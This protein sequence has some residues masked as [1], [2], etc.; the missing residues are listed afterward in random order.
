[1][2]D[3][4]EPRPATPHTQ[5][6]L[7][8]LE[9]PAPSRPSDSNRRASMT[10]GVILLVAG[11][12]WIVA[13]TGWFDIGWRSM[14]AG[15]L[16]V[17]GVAIA[18]IGLSDH[19]P[20]PLVGLGVVLTILLAVTLTV[21]PGVVAGGI[22]DRVEAPTGVS[23]LQDAYRLGIGTLTV[24]LTELSLPA[25]TTE[26]TASVGLGELVVIVPDDVG[27]RVTAD[28]QAGDI[29]VFGD[30]RSGLGPQMELTAE[31]DG[32]DTADGAGVLDLDLAAVFGSIEVRHP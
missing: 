10:V 5:I 14:T 20:G 7:T 6:D 2:S 15:A 16:L 21:P 17:V 25:G 26:V 9:A 8:A 4:R 30:T 12:L 18:G 3:L 23:D 29:A 22:G 24:D 11:V 19:K 28:V 13:E 31:I 1:M 32:V 27:V